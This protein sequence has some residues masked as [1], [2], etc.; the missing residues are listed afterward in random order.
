MNKVPL[1]KT[2]HI[3]TVPETTDNTEPAHTTNQPVVESNNN[4][5]DL[6][7]SLGN[8]Y[9]GYK[10]STENQPDPVQIQ[11]VIIPYGGAG[12]SHMDKAHILTKSHVF[13][14]IFHPFRKN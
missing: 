3:T 9:Q 14:R 6:M 12:K 7:A 5:D 2:P 8:I 10:E 13:F 11:K 1:L 4:L